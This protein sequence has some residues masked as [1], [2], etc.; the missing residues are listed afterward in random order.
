MSPES[1][2]LRRLAGDR[3]RPVMLAIAGDSA[4]GKS[5]L[6]RGLVEA[7]ADS[8]VS[9]ICVDDYHRYDRLERREL[10]FTPL[11]P[12]CNYVGIVEQHMQLLAMGEPILKPVYDHN[13]GTLGRPV[14][15]EPSRN[16]IVEGLLPLHT[17][18]SRACFDLSVYLDPPEAIRRAWKVRRDTLE[19][20]YTE[21]QVLAELER[22]EPDAALSIRPQRRWADIVV[23]FAPIVERGEDEQA[24]LSATLLLRP[25]APHPDLSSILSEDTQDAV[26]LKL[27]RD[28][29][30]KPVDALH[31]HGYATRETTRRV[32][33]AIW[34]SLRME[35]AFPQNLGVIEPG[36]RSE[37]LAVV[38]LILLYHLLMTGRTQ[39]RELEVT[40]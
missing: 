27:M 15:V 18:L 8:G 17:R 40:A 6:T 14:L 10:P 7:L 35:H 26:H 33:E 11:N 21:A 28:D 2:V 19:R 37:P 12:A 39:L 25:T 13:S 38:Q 4:A 9:P 5:T 31:V 32:E 23:R 29:D 3:T 22:R 36:V 24:L 1:F 20:N 30:G 16:V 34:E